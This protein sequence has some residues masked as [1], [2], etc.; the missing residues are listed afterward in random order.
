MTA[1]CVSLSLELTT[2]QHN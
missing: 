1:Y 2:T